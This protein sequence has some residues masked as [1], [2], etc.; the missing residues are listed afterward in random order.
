MALALDADAPAWSPYAERHAMLADINGKV[1]HGLPVIGFWAYNIVN[2]NV[3]NGVLANYA[4]S[5]RHATSVRCTLGGA[6]DCE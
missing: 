5:V 6:S 1:L 4:T 2:N 3:S